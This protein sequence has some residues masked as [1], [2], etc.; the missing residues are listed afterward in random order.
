MKPDMMQNHDKPPASAVANAKR[1]LTLDEK[2]SGRGGLSPSR[3][4]I[5]RRLIQ[6]L[7][8]LVK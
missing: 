1:G 7:L 5:A 3:S 6:E 8:V 4:K 2:S